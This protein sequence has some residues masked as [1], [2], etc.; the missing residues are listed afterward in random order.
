MAHSGPSEHL[1]WAELAC[2]DEGRTPYPECWREER[3]IPLAKAF[4]RI[5]ELCG[6]PILVNSGYRTFDYNWKI[7]GAAK[8]Q[9]MEGRA[10]DLSPVFF[11][12]VNLRK[13]LAAA[14]QSRTEGLITAIGVYPTFIHMDTR[15]GTPRNWGGSRTEN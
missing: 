12:E 2:H 11:T 8:S 5:R 3:A 13:I 10:L 1:S 4:E 15:P 9:H 7:G 14:K 6:F